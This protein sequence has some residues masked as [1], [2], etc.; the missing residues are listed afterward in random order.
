MRRVGWTTY[1]DG[2][3]DE[4]FEVYASFETSYDSMYGS[5]GYGR[6]DS[7]AGGFWAMRV[8]LGEKGLGD[9]SAGYDW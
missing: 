9:V 2:D 3:I 8:P 1:A 7:Y 5:K 4:L 6:G